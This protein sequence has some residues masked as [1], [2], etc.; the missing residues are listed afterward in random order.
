MRQLPSVRAFVD[1]VSGGVATLLLGEEESV[2]THVPVAWLPPEIGEGTV[3]R[4]RFEIDAAA[5]Q[6]GRA[7]VEGLLEE[8]GDQP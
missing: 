5:T 2:T 7:R 1:Q 3:L 8:L 4:L 6:E